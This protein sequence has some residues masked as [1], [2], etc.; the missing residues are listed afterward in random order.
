[1][2]HAALYKN[3]QQSAEKLQRSQFAAG[4]VL[5]LRGIA[6]RTAIGWSKRSSDRTSFGSLSLV[7]PAGMRRGYYLYAGRSKRRRKEMKRAMELGSASF[8]LRITR[9]YAA[10]RRFGR[11]GGVAGMLQRALNAPRSQSAIRAGVLRLGASVFTCSETQ[12][13]AVIAGFRRLK[14]DPTTHVYTINLNIYC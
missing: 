12:K 2:F 13:Q 8:V 1:M 10:A 4:E 9:G 6:R 7:W 11:T 5:A 14:L 3:G